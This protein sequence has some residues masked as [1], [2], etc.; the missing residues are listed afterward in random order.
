MY[1]AGPAVFEALQKGGAQVAGVVLPAHPAPNDEGWTRA[2]G[3]PVHAP[4][5]LSGAD[6]SAW[7]DER[8]FDLLLVATYDRKIPES[9]LA[10]ARRGAFNFHPSL[11]PKYRGH[12]PYFWA[13]R[14]GETESGV[15]LH[16]MTERFDDGPTLLS[17]RLAVAPVETLGSLWRR[18][19]N[20][21]G[22][23]AE[24]FL[25]S[26]AAG[27]TLVETPQG[28][29]NPAPAPRVRDEHLRLAGSHT[30]NEADRI[31]RAANPFYG[32]RATISGVEL[33][34]WEVAPAVGEVPAGE[35][36]RTDATLLFG[37]A[38]GPIE[39]RVAEFKGERVGTSAALLAHLGGF[40]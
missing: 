2:T 36:R 8:P 30:R 22:V 14:N 13:I 25:R 32:A 12:N 33:T 28:E 31:V 16:R 37:C 21:S 17:E 39:I 6:F 20:L 7:L 38:D 9:V 15:T 19:G 1:N 35:V 29:E 3:L 5:D 18:L 40:L 26:L 23:V 4:A 10:R 11:L 34:I 27:E 24:K